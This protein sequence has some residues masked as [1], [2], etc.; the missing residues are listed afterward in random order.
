M[1]KI[2]VNYTFREKALELEV[3]FSSVDEGVANAEKSSFAADG[4][5]GVPMGF[6]LYREGSWESTLKGNVLGFIK[7][8]LLVLETEM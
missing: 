7:I 2:V 8:Y 4:L 1:Q 3:Y 6:W 5:R